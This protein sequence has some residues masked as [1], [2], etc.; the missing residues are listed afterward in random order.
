MSTS[1]PSFLRRCGF[2]LL[3]IMMALTIFVIIATGVFAIVQ[4]T[5]DL[6]TEMTI[7]N[8]QSTIRQNFIEFLRS[9]FRRLP[10][11]AEITLQV[12]ADGGT[13]VPT[14]SIY[15]GGDAFSPGGAIPPDA[16]VELF[17]RQIP[18][19]AMRIGLRMLDME[20]TRSQRGGGLRRPSRGGGDAEQPL[21]DRAL[22]FEWQFLDGATGKW[23]KNWKGQLRPL[24]AKVVMT[25]EDRQETTCIFWIPPIM[26]N[27]GIPPP[28]APALGPDGQPL[29]PGSTAPP[30]TPGVPPVGN[31]SASGA[32]ILSPGGNP[33]GVGQ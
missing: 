6:S 4:G 7:A 23:E 33:L 14:I 21:I 10:G 20:Q 11:D 13:Y 3:E 17:A 2:T 9:S 25:L 15:N 18:G 16:S 28:G 5:L 19:G 32:P 8:E 26:K 29:P 30:G 24:M 22:G 12:T 1:T 31:P 27:S